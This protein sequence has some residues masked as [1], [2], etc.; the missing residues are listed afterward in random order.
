[1]GS[2]LAD[3]VGL[4]H[5]LLADT[6]LQLDRDRA[7]PELAAVNGHDGDSSQAA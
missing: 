3:L 5:L 7:V 6:V 1:M 2:G 4:T